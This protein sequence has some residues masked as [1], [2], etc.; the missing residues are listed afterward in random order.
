M[1]RFE[2]FVASPEVEVRGVLSDFGIPF[3][4]VR[5]VATSTKNPA[6]SLADISAYN[7]REDWKKSLTAEVV[8][9]INASIDWKL[10]AQ[11]GY[12][13]LDPSDYPACPRLITW[14]SLSRSRSLTL[15]SGSR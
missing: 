10:A 8:A 6:I 9:A 15:H 1:I 13:R 2:S 5:R 3:G 14:K 11:H 4:D 12:Y 7:R